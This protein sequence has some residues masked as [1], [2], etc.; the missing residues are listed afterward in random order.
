MLYVTGFT[1]P[2]AVSHLLLSPSAQFIS[3]IFCKLCLGLVC[4]HWTGQEFKAIPLTTGSSQ[5]LFL[6]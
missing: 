6:P 3:S 1:F 2:S 5:F 4:Q